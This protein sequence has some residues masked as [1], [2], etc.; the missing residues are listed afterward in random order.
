M[1]DRIPC[2]RGHRLRTCSPNDANW[3]AALEQ[4]DDEFSTSM[5]VLI[6][7]CSL[8]SE[9]EG[10]CQILPG[11]DTTREAVRRALQQRSFT[12]CGAARTANP[13]RGSRGSVGAATLQL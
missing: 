9:P 5:F 12:R 1:L 4:F 8:L 10:S 13:S 6:L 11:I 7:M 3:T 2:S